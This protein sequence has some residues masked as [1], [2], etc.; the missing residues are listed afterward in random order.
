MKDY[1][2][3]VDTKEFQQ[4]ILDYIGSDKIDEMIINSVFANSSEC[5]SAAIYGMTIASMLMSSCELMAITNA[6]DSK[7]INDIETMT[8]NSNMY[9]NLK[10]LV[11]RFIKIDEEYNHEPWNLEQIIANINMIIPVEIK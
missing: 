1:R 2:I 5:K 8:E 11:E 10:N 9:I 7:T 4:K 3:V 6:E